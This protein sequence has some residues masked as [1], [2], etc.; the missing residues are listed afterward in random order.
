MARNM[1]L[2]QNVAQIKTNTQQKSNPTKNP[3]GR[4]ITQLDHKRLHHWTAKDFIGPQ[5]FSLGHKGSYWTTWDFTGQQTTLLNHKGLHWTTK[6]F[7]ES[8]RTQL[9]HNVFVSFI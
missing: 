3:I 9:P 1:C 4:Q 5:R 6:D 7:T 8:Q 2:V